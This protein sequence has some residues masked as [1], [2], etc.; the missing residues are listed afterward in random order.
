MF[1]PHPSPAISPSFILF[2]ATQ[3]LKQEIVWS[4]FLQFLSL[5]PDYHQVAVTVFAYRHF[6]LINTVHLYSFRFI[7]PLIF[8]FV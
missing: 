4:H 1:T 2:I 7:L 8:D 6:L 3:Y 5:P